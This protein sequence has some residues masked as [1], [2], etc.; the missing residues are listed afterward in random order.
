MTNDKVQRARDLLCIALEMLD[1]CE[2]FVTGAL[3]SGAIDSLDGE[4]GPSGPVVER[5]SLER[6][7]RLVAPTMRSCA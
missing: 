3:V 4:R 6:R 1:E 5:P 7:P 2:T